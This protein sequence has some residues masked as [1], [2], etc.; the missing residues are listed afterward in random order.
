[1]NN[2]YFFLGAAT[3]FW[4]CSSKKAVIGGES[5]KDSVRV[6]YRERIHYI[7]DTVYIKIPLQQTAHTVRDSVSRL[8]NTFSES[9]ARINPD[10]TLYHSLTTKGGS[11]GVEAAT[12]VITRD[13]IVYVGR[14]V[15]VPTP[16]EKPLTAWQTFRLR[17]F[18]LLVA[19]LLALLL[20]TFRKP[21]L[22]WIRKII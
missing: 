18:G 22:F 21:L 19:V 9:D 13:S 11:V 17:W 6:E 3:I 16:V 5:T 12:K 4:A 8:Q 1:M 10:G 14:E 15:K 20:W 7:P 2:V